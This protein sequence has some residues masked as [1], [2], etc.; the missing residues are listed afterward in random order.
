MWSYKN[1]RFIY[2]NPVASVF[3]QGGYIPE[4][5]SDVKSK[6]GLMEA[7]RMHVDASYLGPYTEIDPKSVKHDKPVKF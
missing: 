2:S 1:V 4:L 7:L 6:Y 3:G 5:N